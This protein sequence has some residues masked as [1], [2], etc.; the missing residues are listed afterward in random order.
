MNFL[1]IFTP[2]YNREDMLSNL[3]ISLCN[4]TNKNFKWLIVDDGSTDRTSSLVNLWIKEDRIKIEY[5]KQLNS[6][7]H[8]AHNLALSIINT[9]YFLCVDS[10]DILAPKA[11]DIIYSYVNFE[12]DSNILGFYGRKGDLNGNPT[13]SNWPLNKKYSHLNELYFKDKFKGEAVI[14]LKT[15]LIKQYVFPYFEG[16]KFVTESVFYDQIDNIAPMRLMNEIIYLFEYQTDG[17]T[18]QGINLFFNNPKG[19]AY[20]LKQRATTYGDFILKVKY[21]AQYFAWLRTV[22]VHDEFPNIKIPLKIMVV[23][24][25]LSKYYEKKY[26]FLYNT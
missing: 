14:I 3:Y 20:F 8:I 16:E 24:K 2:T 25:V 26:S 18:N 6:G 9:D 11:V 23:G 10:D 15:K 17:Y 7:K 4:Q 1:T 13:G 5:H 12:K 22:K 19:Y 21:A